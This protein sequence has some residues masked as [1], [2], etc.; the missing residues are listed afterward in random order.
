MTKLH[1]VSFDV[2]FPPNYGG[3]ID[4]FYKI[5]ALHKLGVKIILHT[6]DYGRGKPTELNNY[7]EEIFTINVVL[8]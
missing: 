4:V 3:V 8:F 7:C 6:F 1:I 5:K 2:P